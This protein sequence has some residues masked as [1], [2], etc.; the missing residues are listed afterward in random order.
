MVKFL[1]PLPYFYRGILLLA[2]PLL[3]LAGCSSPAASDAECT[4]N[5][6]RI[7]LGSSI[8][9]V[10]IGDSADEV[11]QK[12]GKP[13]YFAYPDFAGE[14][15]VYAEGNLEKILVSISE[16]PGLGLG[17]IGMGVSY[18]Y[19]GTT[20]DSVGIGASRSEALSALGDPDYS[21]ESYL[22]DLF[23]YYLFDDNQFWVHYRA[24]T[25][26]SISMDIPPRN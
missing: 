12:L 17:V 22:P 10:E 13:S 23:D 5:E 1:A 25:I 11:I 15:Y 2:I 9:C 7:V 14:I 16:D 21:N 20:K 4:Q 6:A 19:R 26:Y 18:P 3:L 8:D 24:D